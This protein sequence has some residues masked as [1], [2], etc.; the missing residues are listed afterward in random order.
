[1]NPLV[2]FASL[3]LVSAVVLLRATDKVVLRT[4]G[5]G[6]V[7]FTLPMAIFFGLMDW[8]ELLL[9][10]EAAVKVVSL[11]L[12]STVGA[13]FLAGALL[14][15]VLRTTFRVGRAMVKKVQQIVLDMMV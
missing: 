8:R 5:V 9:E 15:A 6:A 14:A 11:S 2:L 4:L 10:K 7:L 12:V 3:M 1:M 13:I